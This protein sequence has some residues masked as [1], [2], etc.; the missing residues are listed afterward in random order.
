[1]HF[2]KISHALTKSRVVTLVVSGFLSENCSREHEWRNMIEFDQRAE[3]IGLHWDS[4]SA[5]SSEQFLHNMLTGVASLSALLKSNPLLMAISATY[6]LY[7][8]YINNPF[9]KATEQA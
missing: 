2:E 5:T 8:E 6:L 1:M 4:Q 7:K 3:V 9:Y